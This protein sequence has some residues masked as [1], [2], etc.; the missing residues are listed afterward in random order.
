MAENILY[1][2]SDKTEYAL[3]FLDIKNFKATNELFG[4]EGGDSILRD[5]YQRIGTPWRP[6]VTGRL[7]TDHFLSRF[8]I[9]NT[10]LYVPAVDLNSEQTSARMQ[11]PV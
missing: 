2:A 9:Q 8:H 5:F 7:D 6:A 3:M 1:N 11:H 10:V 4:T